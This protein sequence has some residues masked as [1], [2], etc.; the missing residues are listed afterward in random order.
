MAGLKFT[1]NIEKLSSR[2]AK[3]MR[4]QPRL[5]EKALRDC[6]QKMLSGAKDRA[7]HDEG[8]L[9]TSLRADVVKNAK[10]MAARVY[11]PVNSMAKPYA[12]K[13]HE[14]HYR[15]GANSEAKQME[16]PVTVGR[17]F[18]ERAITE[19]KKELIDTMEF[20]LKRGL[21]NDAD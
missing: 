4:A 2:V 5:A 9:E 17:K 7:P 12:R 15:L 16:V 6:S 10:S 20:V 11:V 19:Q 13:M 14:G 8:T 3:L 18:L 1:V 21:K